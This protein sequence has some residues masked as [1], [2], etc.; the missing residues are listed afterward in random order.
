MVGGRAGQELAPGTFG[1]NLTISDVE[2]ASL[3]IGDRLHVGDPLHGSGVILEV[4]APRIPCW[5]LAQRMGDPGFVKRFRAAGRPGAYC[6]VIR[7]GTIRADALVTLEPYAGE[8]VRVIEVFREYYEPASDPAALR[9][10]LAAPLAVSAREAKQRQLRDV[11]H[12][13]G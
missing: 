8:R 4:A 5:K 6:R 2:S 7:E 11:L 13:G 10:F 12:C 1:E 3:A 9:R